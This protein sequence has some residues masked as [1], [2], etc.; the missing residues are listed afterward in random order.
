M[1]DLSPALTYLGNTSVVELIQGLVYESQV[2]IGT[3]VGHGIRIAGG[4]RRGA[5][6]RIPKVVPVGTALGR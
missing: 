1:G 2:K 3:R 6:A 4:T 5:V